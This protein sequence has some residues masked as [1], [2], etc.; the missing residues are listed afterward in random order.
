MEFAVYNTQGKE[1][2]KKVKLEKEV[3]GIE[4]NEHAVYLD[5]LI[6]LR[7]EQMSLTVPVRLSDKKEQVQP[8]LVALEVQFLLV[9]VQ[10]SD[11]NQETTVSR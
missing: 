9:V 11:Q 5:V 3:F 2:G 1:T 6:R 10:H 8:E 7:Q 4:P